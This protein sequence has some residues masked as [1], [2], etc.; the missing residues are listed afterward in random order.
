MALKLSKKTF[1]GGAH[2]S[3]KKELSATKPIAVCSLPDEVIL[4][5]SQHIG[6][7]AV[8]VVKKGDKVVAGQVVAEAESKVSSRILASVSGEVSAVEKRLSPSGQKCPAIVIKTDKEN[9]DI[10]KFDPIKEPKPEEIINRVR[11]AGIVGLGGAAFPTDIKLQPSKEHKIE[12]VIA[13]GC[14][15][16]P[17]L[18]SDHRQMLE[19]ADALIDGL[20]LAMKVLNAAEGVVA[21]EEN[22][23][24]AIELLSQ[25]LANENNISVL[26]LKTKYP[27][28]AADMIIKT[29]IGKEV[30]VGGRSTATGGFIQNVGTLINISKAVRDGMPMIER[31]VTVSGELVRSPQNFRVRIGTPISHLIKEAGGLKANS[32]KVIIGGPMTGLAQFSF[33]APVIKATGGV[34]VIEDSV[35]GKKSQNLNPCIRCSRCVEACPM[36]LVPSALSIYSQVGIFE[37]AG[38]YD[39]DA[40]IECSSCSYVCP[41][42]RPIVQMIKF[43]KQKI[44]DSEKDNG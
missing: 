44:W 24:D 6:A 42:N 18:T 31:V 34:L 20:K 30:P 1:K 39:I 41:A 10:K 43:A 29:V 17:Y 40:C 5:L 33:N 2:P 9:N 11:E 38:E 26:A 32:G 19:E 12:T 27:Q 36:G 35:N 22:K 21:I 3:Y 14:E 23:A 8:A 25:K 15:C 28:G 37:K 13:N 4:L 16:E 7:P